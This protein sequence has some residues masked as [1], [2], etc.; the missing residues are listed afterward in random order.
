MARLIVASSTQAK[1]DGPG[2]L[3]DRKFLTGMEMYARSWEG[4]VQALLPLSDTAAP[5][6][7]PYRQGDMGFELLTWRPGSG[8]VA[9]A[10]AGADLVM[11]SGDDHAQLDLWKSHRR[12]VYM[13]EYTLEA[14]LDILRL[15]RAGQPLRHAR[16]YAWNLA[17]ER[18]RRR[19]LR[20]AVG[21]QANGYPAW[22]AYG[23]LNRRS[24]IYLDNRID[25]TL[26]ATD[27][28]QA[29]RRD[30]RLRGEPIRLVHSG[31]LERLKG[32]QDLV[33]IC[34]HLRSLGVPFRLDIFGG[35]S[36]ADGLKAEF[37]AFDGAVTMHGMVDFMTELVPYC[38]AQADVFLSCHRQS[39]PSC[40][41]LEAYGCGLPVLGYDNAMLAAL[42]RESG[43]ARTAPMA[44]KRALAGIIAQVAGDPH[45]LAGMSDKALGFAKEH[46]F[47]REFGK[48]IDHLE[49][50][51]GAA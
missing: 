9:E 37:A 49:L 22:D 24:M 30:R 45:R 41:Y 14:R 2:F 44:D 20:E 8:S 31:R 23:A 21:L 25:A 27:G 19:A 13:I 3:V 47:E 29:A 26:F 16:S 17:T 38:R 4:P 46:S 51:L 39:D 36:L 12:V 11:A 6:A 32:S 18:R 48:R 1:S 42:A 33:A 5:Y 28:E 10:V 7:G 35:G 15:D 34:G 50:C 40:T 43:A